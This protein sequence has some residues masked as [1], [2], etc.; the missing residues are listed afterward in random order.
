MNLDLQIALSDLRSHA[1]QLA[2][3]IA[4]IR[5]TIASLPAQIV[6][7]QQDL[8]QAKT[9]W[10]TMVSARGEVSYGP[11]VGLAE[12]ELEK[13]QISLQEHQATLGPLEERLSNTKVSIAQIEEQLGP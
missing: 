9:R 5:Q 8:D 11:E 6:A 3:D 1:T 4:A 7:A 10:G 13:L 12:N 2:K